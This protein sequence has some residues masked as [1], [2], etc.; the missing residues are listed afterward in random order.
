[1]EHS[2]PAVMSQPDRGDLGPRQ[3]VIQQYARYPAALESVLHSASSMGSAGSRVP[4][5]KSP[6][7]HRKGTPRSLQAS[8]AAPRPG[9]A[10]A[11][12]SASAARSGP[13]MSPPAVDPLR[14]RPARE[15]IDR[16]ESR[17]LPSRDVTDE[18]ID[19]AYIAFIL[20]CNPNV[21]ITVDSTELRK[22]FRSPPRSDGK[23]FSIF[24][25]WQLIRRLDNKDLKTWI[26]LAIELGVEPPSFEKKQST[27]KVQQYTVRLKVCRTFP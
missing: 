4:A 6:P 12:A 23:S 17:T 15:S 22:T 8:P 26:Q 1:M 21:P 27:Q 19:D 10:P 2:F 25:L 5:S 24:N 20:Y 18:N 13:S 14:Q 16:A 3:M 7:L 9:I 11:S